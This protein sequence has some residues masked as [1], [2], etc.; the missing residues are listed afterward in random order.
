MKNN[1]V[2]IKLI[3]FLA[4]ILVPVMVFAVGNQTAGILSFSLENPL[5]ANNFWDLLSNFI[6]IAMKIG[7]PVAVFFF[8]WSGF[9]Y[10]FA[11]GNEAKIRLAHK[12]LKNVVLGTIIFLGAWTI[13]EVVVKTIQSVV[14]T[15]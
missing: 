2:F 10:I 5:L 14:G 1:K 3:S 6:D 12:N 15:Q 13:T 4:I 11:G 8:I 7:I 9:Q